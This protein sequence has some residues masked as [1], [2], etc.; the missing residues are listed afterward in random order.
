MEDRFNAKEW[1]RLT[2]AQKVRRCK[3]MAAEAQTLAES[4]PPKIREDYLR[5]ATQ[6]LTLAQDIALQAQ[7]SGDTLQ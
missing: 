4:A 3:V 6:W 5:L 7:S 1:D 2:P